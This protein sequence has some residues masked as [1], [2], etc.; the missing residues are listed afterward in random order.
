MIFADTSFLI[1]LVRKSDERHPRAH[2]MADNL[3]ERVI[4][5]GHV[6]SEFVTYIAFK[7]GN[8]CAYESGK[9]LL[10]SE[11]LI[12]Y[13]LQED[14][15]SALEYVRKHPKLSMCDALSATIMKKLGISKVLSFDSDFDILGFERLA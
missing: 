5:S 1:A 4:I 15:P 7:D 6:F 14:I 10:G 8:K 12:V 3:H 11:F 13:A 9:K 2:E